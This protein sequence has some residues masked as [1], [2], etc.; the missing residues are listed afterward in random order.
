MP[1]ISYPDHVSFPF[2][3]PLLTIC[4][5]AQISP[6]FKYYLRFNLAYLRLVRLDWSDLNKGEQR[7]TQTKA[8]I[9]GIE[10]PTLITPLT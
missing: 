9:A 5:P 8:T 4:E 1:H 3:T 6:F 2:L 10:R 7:N